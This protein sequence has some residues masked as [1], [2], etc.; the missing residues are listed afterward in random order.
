MIV[1]LENIIKMDQQYYMN[2]FGLRTPVCFDKGEGVWLYDTDGNKY[3]DFFAGIAVTALGHAHPALVRAMSDQ[4]AK[5]LHTSNLYY[6]EPQAKLAKILCEVSCADKVFFSNSGAEANEGALKLARIYFYKKGQTHK[7]EIITL[8]NSFHGRTLATVA[9]TGQ[10][11]YQKPYSPLM[12]GFSHVE[13]GNLAALKAAITPNTAAIML[14]AIQGESGVHPC[15]QEYITAVRQL[16]DTNDIL[17]II[18]E[19]QT[20]IGR[21]GKMFGYQHYGIEPDIFT[22][23]KALGGGVPIGAICAK[24]AVCAFEPGDHGSTFGGNPLATA[25]GLAVMQTIANENLVQNAADMGKYFFTSLESLKSKYSCI[26]EIRA[27]GLM[28]GVEFC[29]GLGAAVK[30]KLFDAHVL[31]GLVGD[32][33]RILPPLI[34]T[35][36]DVDMFMDVLENVVKAL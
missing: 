6:T 34:I 27:V 31:T 14:E 17:L 13:L 35:T 26:K 18:D 8:K 2:T 25:A 21:T 36:A 23:A 16:C 19:V 33:L 30:Q 22:V 3:L 12:P 15:E 9:A 24:D 11:K 10:P 4:A 7:T 1:M 5:L 32:T 29:D 28:L 20:G